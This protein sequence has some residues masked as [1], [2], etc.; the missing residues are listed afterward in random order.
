M[1]INSVCLENSGSPLKHEITEK[2]D[3]MCVTIFG[4]SEN[5][6]ESNIDW[7]KAGNPDL[8]KL[9]QTSRF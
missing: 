2:S 7:D 3:T 4:Q 6:D 5:N 9:Y 8:K 1:K